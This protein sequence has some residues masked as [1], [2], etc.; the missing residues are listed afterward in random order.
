[1]SQGLCPNCDQLTK[2]G[3]NPKIGENVV[4]AHCGAESIVVWLNPIELDLPY[5]DFTDDDD[6]YAYNYEDDDTYYDDDF[7]DAP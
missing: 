3:N 6:D 1:M 7:E 4:C 5:D 2:V